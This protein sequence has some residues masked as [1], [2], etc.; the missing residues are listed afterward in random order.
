[1]KRKFSALLVLL[2]IMSASLLSAFQKH[3]SLVKDF[4]GSDTVVAATD[5]EETMTKE[6][7]IAIIKD[8]L[9]AEVN[10]YIKSAAPRS[11]M[12]AEHIIDKCLEYDYDI[13]LLLSQ[14][15]I[16]SRFG[17]LGRNVFGL[18]GKSYKHPDHAVV[19]Y[20]DLMT[21]KFI[22]NRSP[23]E[24]ISSGFTWENN[25]RAKYAENPNY[26]NEIRKIR[27]SMIKKTEIH[28]LYTTLK[29]LANS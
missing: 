4:A 14:G 17:T 22:I 8:S 3:Y 27:N 16:E 29:K 19:D 7:S 25:S 18:Y 6:D 9:V 15:Y 24:L 26:S 28:T 12:T 23:D 5:I 2:I 10:S 1:M 13:T 11:R 20:L 21:R